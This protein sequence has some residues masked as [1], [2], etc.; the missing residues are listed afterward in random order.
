ML[1]ARRGRAN[2]RTPEA[3]DRVDLHLLVVA[4]GVAIKRVGMAA[5]L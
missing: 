2:A 4:R 5:C 1:S 3:A